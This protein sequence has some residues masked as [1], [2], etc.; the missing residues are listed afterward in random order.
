MTDFLHVPVLLSETLD[1][2]NLRAMPAGRQAG[3]KVVDCT[4]G[5]GGHSEAILKKIGKSGKLMAFDQDETNLKKAK[6]R[7]KKFEK[8]VTYVHSNFEN[9]K[10]KI[11]N[12]KFGAPDA[13]LFDLGLSSPHVDKPERGFSFQK[14]G[15][16]DMRYDQTQELTAQIVINTYDEKK[17]ADLIYQY[18][19]ERRS[20]VIARAIVNERKK[21]SITN[22]LQLADIIKAATKGKI[23]HHPATKT[24]QALRIYV[25]RELEVLENALHQAINALAPK[26]RIVVISYHSLEDRLVKNIFR[27][28][29]RD[30]ICPKELPLCQCD[31]QKKLYLLTKR[32]II[33]TGIEVAQNPRSRSAKLRAA[34]RL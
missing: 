21:H 20:R 14:E 5:L 24:F 12:L 30:C 4:L 7:L 3:N 34:E 27:Y 29:T 25:N 11:E 22:T 18:G 33:P 17:L 2:L 28:Y 31:F 32:P 26:G 19:E 23:G 16:L 13:I 8:Q 10:L 6:Q 1:L 15:S 9:L